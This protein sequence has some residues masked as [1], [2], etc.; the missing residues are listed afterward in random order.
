[1]SDADLKSVFVYLQTLKPVKHQL[2]NFEPPTYCRLCRQKH[3]F[4][5]TN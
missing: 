3:G 1:M 2:D 4:G 5:A